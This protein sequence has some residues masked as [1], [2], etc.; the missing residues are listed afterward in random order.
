MSKRLVPELDQG[1][2]F[3]ANAGGMAVQPCV[4]SSAAWV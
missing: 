4:P 2:Y 3:T 1:D